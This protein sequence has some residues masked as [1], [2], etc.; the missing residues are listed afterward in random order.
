MTSRRP[1]LQIVVLFASDTRVYNYSRA[2]AQRFNDA[3][4][5]VFINV[6]RPAS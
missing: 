1:L 4:V 6:R 2:V 5:D 3:G